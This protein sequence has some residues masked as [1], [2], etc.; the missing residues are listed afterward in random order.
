MPLGRNALSGQFASFLP[1]GRPKVKTAPPGGSKPKARRGGLLLR[2][3][4]G[5]S[6]SALILAAG[7]V[8]AHRFLPA[9]N[10]IGTIHATAPGS[11]VP[12]GNYEFQGR[13]VNVADGDTITLLTDDS[14]QH[15]VRLDSIDAPEASHGSSEP[16]QPFAE[17]ARKN[18]AALVAGKRITA[19]CYETDQYHRDV[20]ALILDDGSSA[21]RAQVAGGFAWAYTARHGAYLRDGAM[22]GLQREAKQAGRGLWAQAG[23]NEPWKWR[24]DC[25]KQ[26]QCGN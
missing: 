4:L 6:L 14:K 11:T 5:V 3:K 21:N 26:R 23:A 8:L 10:G 15:R 7:G 19:R 1:P 20:C 25:W 24:Y 9:N 12:A 13:V 2:R 16:G 17:A 18:L 22:P